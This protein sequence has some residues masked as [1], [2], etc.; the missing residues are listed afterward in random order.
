MT[1]VEQA[2]WHETNNYG[3]SIRFLSL[4]FLCL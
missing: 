4:R 3:G 1:R 2:K